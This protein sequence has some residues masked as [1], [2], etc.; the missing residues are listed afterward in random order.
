MK[1]NDWKLI[2]FFL[3][4]AGVFF[5]WNEMRGKEGREA[6]IYVDGMEYQ[7]V[8]LWK[9]QEIL[10]GTGNVV[11]TGQGSAHMEAADCP[12]QICVHHRPVS[13]SG[14]SIVCLPNRVVVEI[15]GEDCEVDVTAY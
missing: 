1:K 12:D 7:R 13:K 10:V 11:V 14:E 4:V 8:S 5:F 15:Q 6:V 9:E 3:I 2:V